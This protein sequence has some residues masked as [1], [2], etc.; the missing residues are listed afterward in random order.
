MLLNRADSP[1]AVFSMPVVF[2]KSAP[3]PVA[4][5]P[6]A[7]FERSAPAPTAVLKLEV[8]LPACDK[9]PTAVLYRPLVRNKKA[10]CPAAVLPPG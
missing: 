10:C 7:T 9:K 4:V 2:F 8:A 3:A 5:F 1:M 6:S